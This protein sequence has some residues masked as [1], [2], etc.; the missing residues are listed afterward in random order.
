MG[1]FGAPAYD[2]AVVDPDPKLQ[3]RLAL[4]LGDG[5][6]TYSEPAA[7]NDRLRSG[8][9]TIVVFGPSLSTDSGLA[10]IER[11]ARNHPQLG[12]ILV[13]PELSTALLQKALRSGVRDVLGSPTEPQLLNE[14]V[15][16]VSGT[17]TPIAAVPVVEGESGE[18][19]RVITVASTKGGSGK[20]V[21]ATNLAVALARR[22]PRPVALVDADLQFGDVAVMLRLMSTHTMMDAVAAIDRLDAD[23]LKGLLVRHEASGLLVLPGPTEPSYADRISGADVVRVVEVLQTFCSHVVVDTPAALND[24]VVSL[25]EHSDDV[26]LVAG[27][28]IPSIKNM[29]LGLQTLRLLSV[30]DAKLL[31]VLNRAHS[32]VKLDVGEVERTLG[33]KA[34]CLLPSDI[35]V[36]QTVNKGVPVVLDA[37]RSGVARA[38]DE[39]ADRFA[40][41]PALIPGQVPA[42][43]PA[44]S[45]SFFGLF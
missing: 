28:E 38:I 26:V 23:M 18:R 27:M 1:A 32:D 3:A 39:L 7:L 43:S 41:V 42:P 30:P 33:L 20:S 16:R 31:L 24:V 10:A 40:D 12:A 22:S 11:L 36:P 45:R 44:R 21:V 25:V 34:S 15:M 6:A 4:Q 14:S 29:R 9:P 13:V 5:A 2:L 17:L 8:R 19:G 35:V 37:P